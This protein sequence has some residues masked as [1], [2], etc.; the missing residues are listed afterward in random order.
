MYIEKYWENSV[1]G[2][3]DTMT[4]MDYLEYKQK[5]ELTISEILEETGLSELKGNYRQTDVPLQVE[6]E[7]GLEAEM[8]YA[9][10]IVAVLAALILE[11]KVNGYVN[12]Q[13]LDST[14]DEFHI[15]LLATEDE[16]NLFT[17]ALKDYVDNSE[18]YDIVEM[19]TEDELHDVLAGCDSL[20]RELM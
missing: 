11:C 10:D 15:K 4:F 17:E 20:R 2:S 6:I 1:G 12:L 9:I 18:E 19:M 3:D 8:H 16:L 14:K 13:D 5:S 7:E